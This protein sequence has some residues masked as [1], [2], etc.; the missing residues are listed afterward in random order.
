MLR[1]DLRPGES[2]KIGDNVIL[3]L[4]EKSGRAARIAFQAD[5]SVPIVRVQQKSSAAQ[6]MKNGIGAVPAA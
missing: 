6:L 2:V 4:E 5:Q 1:I 3:T